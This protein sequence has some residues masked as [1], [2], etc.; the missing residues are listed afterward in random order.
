MMAQLTT[1]YYNQPTDDLQFVL[2]MIQN[3]MPQQNRFGL[4]LKPYAF[5]GYPRDMLLGRPFQDI[6]ISVPSLEVARE[7][8]QRLEQS[9]RI[10]S[11]E[12]RTFSESAMPDVDYQCFSMVIQTPKTDKLKIDITYSNALVLQEESLRNCDFTINNLIVDFKGK[13]STRIKAY[14]IGKGLEYSE[15]EW[16]SKC[17]QDCMKRELVWMIPDRFSKIL[18]PTAKNLFMEKMNMRLEKMLSKGFVLTNEHLT[19]FR[20]MKIRP[21]SSLSLECDATICAICR[22][23]YDEDLKKP[24]SVAECSHHFHTDCIKKWINKKLEDDQAEPK[25]PC[26]RQEIVLYY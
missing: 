6:D 10:F 2:G 7:F 24:T 16:T 3:C 12:T 13:I 21:V 17:I 5:G 19:S 15:A 23:N 26:C 20:I 22:Q 25:C 18:S 4:L 9:C 1:K 8:I 14:Q 11:L